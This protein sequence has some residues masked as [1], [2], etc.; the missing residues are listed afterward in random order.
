M[1]QIELPDFFSARTNPR[2]PSV[3]P[4]ANPTPNNAPN[5][6][7]IVLIDTRPAELELPITTIVAAMESTTIATT[8][9]RIV[10]KGVF[11]MF[12]N[13]GTCREEVVNIE[14]YGLIGTT[15]EKTTSASP[16]PTVPVR[17][18]NRRNRLLFISAKLLPKYGYAPR[19]TYAVATLKGFRRIWRIIPVKKVTIEVN[20]PVMLTNIVPMAN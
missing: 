6:E 1:S 14:L 13:S 4:M 17:I 5:A 19:F 9:A 15:S 7:I 18:T 3:S 2:N 20:S 11:I 12:S 8:N 16:A 10:Y